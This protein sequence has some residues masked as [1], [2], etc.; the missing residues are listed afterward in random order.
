MYVATVFV[1]NTA[2]SNMKKESPSS[3]QPY[4]AI[5]RL[6]HQAGEVTSVGANEFLCL[7]ANA[8]LS[9][10]YTSSAASQVFFSIEKM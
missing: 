7:P 4:H 8:V 10:K 5:Q 9:V 1:F 2:T 6:R 3:S